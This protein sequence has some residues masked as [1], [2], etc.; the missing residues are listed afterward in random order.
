MWGRC[1]ERPF[2]IGLEVKWILHGRSKL[3]PYSTSERSSQ[4]S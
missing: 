3:R 4:R 1:L 2:F